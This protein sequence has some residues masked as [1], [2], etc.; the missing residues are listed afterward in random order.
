MK[1][2]GD[3]CAVTSSLVGHH[4]ASWCSGGR[5]KMAVLVL[6]LVAANAPCVT[7]QYRSPRITEHP[8]DVVVPKN[9]PVTLNCKAE[10]RPQPDIEWWKDGQRLVLG[11]GTHRILLPTG[12][13][14]F[15]RLQHGRKEHDDGVYWCVARNTA[16]SASS[17][18]ATLQVADSSKPIVMKMKIIEW[19]IQ[20]ICACS[21][22][23]TPVGPR[24]KC[25]NSDPTFLIQ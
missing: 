11:P 12:S 2:C 4:G 7:G 5:T 19:L 3:W 8:A 22:R 21:Q 24:L 18:N 17:R 23:Y 25:L 6:L 15:L 16:G 10:G 9:E 14:F 13:L 20:T 1:D